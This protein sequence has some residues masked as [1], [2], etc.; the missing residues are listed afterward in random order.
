MPKRRPAAARMA[1]TC[2]A[3]QLS[4]K[5]KVDEARARPP[6]PAEEVSLGQACATSDLG[7]LDGRHAREAWPTAD[8]SGVAKS[9]IAS[10]LGRSTGMSAGISKAGRSP[11]FLGLLEGLGDALAA[12]R[13]QSCSLYFI[14]IQFLPTAG[15]PSAAHPACRRFSIVSTTS[16]LHARPPRPP[17][18]PAP[19][20]RAPAASCARRNASLRAG[21]RCR[22]IMAILMMSAAVP[23]MGMLT[24]ARSAARRTLGLAALPACSSGK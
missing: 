1:S 2:A 23:W 10:C 17:A 11:L 6:Q 15:P 8:R 13:R 5:R 16:R 9:P 7:D 22:R 20:R 3:S 4:P 18:L 14:S 12:V 21:A 19:A 24:A